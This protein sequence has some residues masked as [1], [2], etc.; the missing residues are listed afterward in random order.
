[1]ADY[2]SNV[3]VIIGG[4]LACGG[5]CVA[6]GVMIT[7]LLALWITK[8]RQQ[9]SCVAVRK[10]QI[11]L[12]SHGLTGAGQG[13][14]PAPDQLKEVGIDLTCTA[15]SAGTEDGGISILHDSEDAGNY[16][17][18]LESNTTHT[19]E[20]SHTCE[21]ANTLFPTDKQ[22][23]PVNANALNGDK[24]TLTY[25]YIPAV[26]QQKKKGSMDEK[27]ALDGEYGSLGPA[28]SQ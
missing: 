25:E 26:I 2:G 15:G 7:L 16:S 3:A 9:R 17:S 10:T 5:V 12:A 8:L 21:N 23:D 13:S 6:L 19:R 28:A 27:D 18:S 1:M 24:G 22:T 11:K 4:I 14:D 20:T